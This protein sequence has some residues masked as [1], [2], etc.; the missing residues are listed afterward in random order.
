[1][2]DEGESVVGK[3][4]PTIED[5]RRG[6]G[7]EGRHLWILLCTFSRIDYSNVLSH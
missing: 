2:R 6:E 5:V 7:V 1:M 3:R 4:W